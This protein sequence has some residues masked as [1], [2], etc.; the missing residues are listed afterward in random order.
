MI[1]TRKQIS[2]FILESKDLFE[3]IFVPLN[4]RQG[5]IRSKSPNIPIYFYRYIGI[6][7]N[8]EIYYEN[9]HKLN[10]ELTSLQDLYL[11]FTSG[12]PM[13]ILSTPI[14]QIPWNGFLSSNS[15]KRNALIN[16]LK[17]KGLLPNFKDNFFNDY[18]ENS[19][20][21]TLALYL[22]N[23]PN[24]TE[25]VIK[26]FAVKFLGWIGEFV[27]KLLK[28]SDYNPNPT[29]DI[30]NPKVLFYGEIKK[31]EIYFLIFLSKL[32]CDVLYINSL[33]DMN[34][35]KID[36]EN[37]YSKLIKLPKT[38]PLIDLNFKTNT[39]YTKTNKE[40]TSEFKETIIQMR[41]AC[42]KK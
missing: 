41:P 32:G 21:E 36:K 15:L 8:K 5:F 9:L 34:F 27:P 35:P 40:V 7:E 30:I 22:T 25:T 20:D 16:I 37:I 12:I 28:N 33:S 4:K 29:K 11:N 31:H 23:E 17:T 26:N 39:N 3:D 1:N 38:E 42:Y 24:I 19:L 6:S 2:T 13:K 18:I 10:D 14:T